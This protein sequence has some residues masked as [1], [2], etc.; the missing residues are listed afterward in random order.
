MAAITTPKSI[1]KKA[2]TYPATNDNITPKEARDRETALYHANLIQQRKD[3]ELEILLS[4]EQLIDF[5]LAATPY[6]ASNPS[7]ADAAAFK[8][9]LRIFQ[10]SDYDAMIEERNIDKRCGYALCPKPKPESSTGKYRILGMRGKAKDFR[11]VQKEEVERW[12]SDACGQRALY[13]KVQLNE[14]PA[15]ERVSLS[16]DIDLLDEPKSEEGAVLGRLGRLQLAAN[17]GNFKNS[18]DLA[19]ERGDKGRAAKFGKV[20][21]EIQEKQVSNAA[22][23]PSFPATDLNGQMNNMHLSVEGYK[24]GFEKGKSLIKED[25][26]DSGMDWM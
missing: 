13:V 11:V 18:A 5:P 17:E 25:E 16:T 21:V 24:S 7:P 9:Y 26:E 3:L 20:E 4:L 19:L 12:C 6:D 23:P 15:W 22:E 2:P 10:P 14:S 8:H 1:L